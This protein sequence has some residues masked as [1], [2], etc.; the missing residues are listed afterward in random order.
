MQRTVLQFAK[1]SLPCLSKSLELCSLR[2]GTSDARS[3]GMSVI[4]LSFDSSTQVP[5]GVDQPSG[6][7][8]RFDRTAKEKRFRGSRSTGALAQRLAR[9]EFAIEHL[10]RAGWLK[11][12]RYRYFCVR[13]HWLFL[14]DNRLGDA[15][16]VDGSGRPLREPE[17]SARVASFAL[18]PCPAA[19]NQMGVVCRRRDVGHRLTHPATACE[20]ES[21]KSGSTPLRMLLTALRTVITKRLSSPTLFSSFENNETFR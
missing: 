8:L 1:S 11:P 16:A 21:A 5:F 9:H 17:Q 2:T 13:C 3:R 12:R 10:G 6:S 4:R 18:G 19:R 14:I 15:T 7:Q 20:C